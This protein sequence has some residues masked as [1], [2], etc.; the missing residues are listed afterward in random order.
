[1]WLKTVTTTVFCY[2]FLQKNCLGASAQNGLGLGGWGWG[3]QDGAGVL[4][5][6]FPDPAAASRWLGPWAVGP[7]PISD[8]RNGVPRRPGLLPSCE[9][10]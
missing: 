7:Q 3:L 8:D 6:R 5:K 10:N 1:M 2:V 9:V 4:A